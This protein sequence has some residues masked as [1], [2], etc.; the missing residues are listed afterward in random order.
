MS[1]FTL[2]SACSWSSFSIASRSE[3]SV[4]SPGGISY[5]NTKVTMVL[6]ASCPK[7]QLTL[8]LR[9]REA[10]SR[11]LLFLAN[12]TTLNSVTTSTLP[13]MMVVS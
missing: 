12:S 11:I 4:T 13:K 10:L 6:L 5:S 7:S 3:G 1:S 9:P 2:F 8:D